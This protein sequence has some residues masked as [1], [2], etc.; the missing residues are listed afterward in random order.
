MFYD[1]A[2]DVYIAMNFGSNTGMVRSFKALIDVE[3]TLIRRMH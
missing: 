2:N 3:N 1:P